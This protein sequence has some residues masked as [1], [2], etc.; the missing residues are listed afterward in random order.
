MHQ[1][2]MLITEELESANRALAD[3]YQPEQLYILRVRMRRI[4]SI[5]KHLDNRRARRFRK[6][7]GGFATVTNDARDWD[8]FLLTAA[9]DLAAGDL[10]AFEQC[11]AERIQSAHGAVLDM[12]GS[13]AWRR[14]LG[15]WRNFLRHLD[16]QEPD[17]QAALDRALNKGRRVLAAAFVSD[18]DRKWH[19]FRIAVKEVRYVADAGSLE[20]GP[21][22]EYEC[23]AAACSVV[24]TLLGNWHDTVVQLDLLDELSASPVHDRLAAVI[25]DRKAA[26]LA[27]MHRELDDH[28]L[29]S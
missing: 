3:G 23:I 19:K 28:P 14:Q 7:W 18:A 12:I 26:L 16:E 20:S 29:F 11:H 1:Q 10:R 27:E 17:L 4:R 22:S 21:G 9:A 6:A 13:A 15:E 8:V 24:Q 25:R 2:L 5:L